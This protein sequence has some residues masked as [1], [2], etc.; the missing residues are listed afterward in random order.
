MSQI[1]PPSLKLL[2]LGHLV[3]AIRKV[4]HSAM[5]LLCALSLRQL[6]TQAV[7]LSSPLRTEQRET[8]AQ[9]RL[10]L[11]APGTKAASFSLDL[12]DDLAGEEYWHRPDNLSPVLG[13]HKGAGEN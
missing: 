7:C 11:K 5:D 8:V 1:H 12:R 2:P 3:T 4:I 10:V 6:E 9:T 13:S